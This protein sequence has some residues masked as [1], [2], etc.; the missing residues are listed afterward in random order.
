MQFIRSWTVRVLY[1]ITVFFPPLCT[2]FR[3]LL[4]WLLY[5]IFT[6]NRILCMYMPMKRLFECFVRIFLVHIACNV[7]FVVF[8]LSELR[9]IFA[10]FNRI[11]MRV[12]QMQDKK[13]LLNCILLFFQ[14]LLCSPRSICRTF[15]CFFFFHVD[16]NARCVCATSKYTNLC[17]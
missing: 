16:L 2:T 1:H 7:L 15:I 10:P 6:V 13:K 8:K 12:L 5:K 4:C 3:L 17:C 11:Q 9:F 14:S